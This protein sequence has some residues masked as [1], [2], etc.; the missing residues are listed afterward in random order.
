MTDASLRALE[1]LDALLSVDH[2]V[3]TY[4][5][6]PGFT[7]PAYALGA[8]A[9]GG[10]VAVQRRSDRGHPGLAVI[11]AATAVRRL[12]LSEEI[13]DLVRLRGLTHVSVPR[14]AFEHVADVHDWA[15]GG[16]WD[17]MWTT[18]TLPTLPHESDIEIVD[19][20]AAAELVEFLRRANPRTHGEPFAR[21]DQLWVTLRDD[22]ALVAC[23]SWDLATSGIPV[24]TGIAVDPARRGEGYGAAITAYLTRRAVST[25]GACT[26]GMFADNLTA[27]LLYHRLGYRTGAQWSSRWFAHGADGT[28]GP[29]RAR[30]IG[31][32]PGRR[33]AAAP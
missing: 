2:P 24:L 11:G 31:R 32:P 22:R 10:A 7:P 26:L 12:L 6:G 15:G 4:D 21:P 5:I 8:L 25:C 30:P 14:A 16:E 29:D 13:G 19:D 9:E 23:G 27:R 28:N 1:D 33:T 20:A 18:T 17:W 3:L